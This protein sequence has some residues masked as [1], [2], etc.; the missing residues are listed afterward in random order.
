MFFKRFQTDE[1]PLNPFVCF[2]YFSYG[3]CS[4]DTLFLEVIYLGLLPEN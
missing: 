3:S 4:K 1:K 2:S